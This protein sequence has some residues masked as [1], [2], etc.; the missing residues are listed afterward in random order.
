MSRSYR[1]PLRFRITR[2]IMRPLFRLIFHLLSEVRLNGLENIPANGPYLLVFNHVSIF[3]PPFLVAFWPQPPEVLGAID[4]WSKPG[5][6]LLARLYGG[7]PIQRGEIDRNAMQQ[8]LAVLKAGLPLM[9]A[10]EGGRSHVPGMR[11]AKPG[12]VYLIDRTHVPIV[13]VGVIGT[14]DDFFKRA[15]QGRRPVLE[16][17][18]GEPFS[19]PMIEP[20]DLSPREVRQ[21]RIDYIMMRI[22]ALLPY[23]YRGRYA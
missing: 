10:P 20:R 13:P 12:T 17:K 16:M 22:A 14:T 1:V 9:V 6:S 19:L 11:P 15:I 2:G 3:D 7:I 5:Q 18:I 4:V 23:E 21:Q 8:M